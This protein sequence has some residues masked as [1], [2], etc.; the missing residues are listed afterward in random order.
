METGAHG[1][2]M[3]RCLALKDQAPRR[4]ERE[5]REPVVGLDERDKEIEIDR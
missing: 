4:D 5:M 1:V 3:A 2:S